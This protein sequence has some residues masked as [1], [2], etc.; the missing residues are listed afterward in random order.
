LNGRLT[1]AWLALTVLI[2]PVAGDIGSCRQEV[3]ELDSVKFFTEKKRIDCGKCIE[4]AFGSEL[5]RV[6]C[7]EPLDPEEAVFPEQCVPLVHDG[8][9]CLNALGSASCDEYAAYVDDR[10]A[11]VPTE[12]NFCPFELRPQAP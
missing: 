9:V 1:I 3:A 6:A 11:F 8:E 10:A 2:A 7:E 12:C 5:C 4:C